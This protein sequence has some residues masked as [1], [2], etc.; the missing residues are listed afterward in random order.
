MK[1]KMKSTVSKI[2]K[3]KIQLDKLEEKRERNV[4]RYIIPVEM[5][6]QHVREQLKML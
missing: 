6:I 3:L 1:I 5:K 4:N 2:K